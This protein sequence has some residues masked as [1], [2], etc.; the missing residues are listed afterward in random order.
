MTLLPLAI[1]LLVFSI[2]LLTGARKATQPG[3]RKA[4]MLLSAVTGAAAIVF[5][6]LAVIN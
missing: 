3:S 6:I 4:L 5:A 1:A 2:A